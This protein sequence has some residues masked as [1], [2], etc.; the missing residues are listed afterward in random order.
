MGNEN[1]K[2]NCMFHDK[3]SKVFTFL[4]SRC[5]EN[6]IGPFV[7]F[8]EMTM[9]SIIF[10]NT[11]PRIVFLPQPFLLCNQNFLCVRSGINN[12]RAKEIRF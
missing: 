1:N 12:V 2:K 11:F 10:E 8:S 3:S 4:L 5:D 9:R 7:Y 6:K